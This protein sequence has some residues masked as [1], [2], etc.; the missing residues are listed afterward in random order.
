MSVERVR[1]F[2]VRGAQSYS[3]NG[4]GRLDFNDLT[5]LALGHTYV[6]WVELAIDVTFA[7]ASGAKTVVEPQLHNV[8]K[9]LKCGIP[10]GH[11]FF[12]LSTQAG[13]S[14]YKATWIVGGIR[15][16]SPGDL[17]VGAGGSASARVKLMLPLGYLPGAANPDDFNVPL[18]ELQKGQ[19]A[20]EFT[21]ANGAAGGDFDATAGGTGDVT[22]T[23]AQIRAATAVLIA[24]P[25]ASVGPY[26]TWK[27]QLL[28][29]LE[30]RPLAANMILL[31]MLEVPTQN[32]PGANALTEV[33]VTA[34]GRTLVDELSFDGVN[35]IE[36]VAAADL[37]T[38]ANRRMKTAADRITQHEAGTTEVLPIYVSP[39]G[40]ITHVPSS[41]D[42]PIL[43][44]QGT[45]T[46]PRIVMVM[47]RMVDARAVDNSAQLLGVAVPEG[48]GVAKSLTKTD[49]DARSGAG[50][51]YRLRRK[52]G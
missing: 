9:S 15:P 52:L 25:E 40:K 1:R 27:Q 16:E 33:F 34:A 47:A 38:V 14:L 31:A 7:S 46:T 19:A 5:P 35:V 24:R 28:S 21:W 30:E 49:V 4:T 8:I 6:R 18:R 41:R 36:Q 51:F 43:K 32:G 2:Q 13:E 45:T 26:L 12:D 3:A 10:G 22:I 23:S 17:S 11:T 48:G 20:I 29:G 50:A 39:S 42:N 44:L 37:I